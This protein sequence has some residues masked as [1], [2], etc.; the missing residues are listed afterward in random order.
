VPIGRVAYIIAMLW[1]PKA[2]VLRGQ[3]HNIALGIDDTGTSTA[4]S[5]INADIVVEVDIQLLPGVSGSFPGSLGGCTTVGQRGHFVGCTSY[6][7]KLRSF[8]FHLGTRALGI[9]E[10]GQFEVQVPSGFELSSI[11]RKE[12]E[13]RGIEYDSID[14]PHIPVG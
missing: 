14:L 6:E 7:M 9:T 8:C 11:Y 13:A 10:I 4:S 2:N 5:D 1:L 3:P 12:R